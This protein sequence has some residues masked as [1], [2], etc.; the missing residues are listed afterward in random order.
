M[1]MFQLCPTL[2]STS[3]GH[4]WTSV[5]PFERKTDNFPLRALYMVGIT[6]L[7]KCGKIKHMKVVFFAV[8]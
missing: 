4:L 7:Y 2:L 6:L 3:R 5:E 8:V 1:E